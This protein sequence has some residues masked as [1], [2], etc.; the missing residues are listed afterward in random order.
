MSI[1]FTLRLDENSHQLVR[2][3][4]EYLK[5]S[6]F[7]KGTIRGYRA[8]VNVIFRLLGKLELGIRD[9]EEAQFTEEFFKVNSAKRKQHLSALKRFL[10]IKG[11]LPGKS[12][13]STNKE[14]LENTVT[15]YLQELTIRGYKEASIISIRCDT[16]KF[17][18]LC[19]QKGLLTLDSLSPKLIDDFLSELFITKAKVYCHNQKIKILYAVRGFFG[20][21]YTSGRTLYN[22]ANHVVVPKREKKLSRNFFSREEVVKLF[23]VVD[24][25]TLLGF[26]DR[27]IF[28]VLYVTGM[29]ISE[30]C[31]LRCDDA[32]K[33]TGTLYVKE[34][35]G[36]QDRYVPLGKTAG[37]YLDLYLADVR[38]RILAQAKRV[39]HSIRKSGYLFVTAKGERLTECVITRIIGRYLADAG[40]T[41]RRTAH[42]FRYSCATHLLENGA[43]I[44]HI[45]GLLGHR[46]LDTTG[47]YAKVSTRNM[48]DAIRY[49]PRE[50][51]Q[52]SSFTGQRREEQ[53]NYSHEL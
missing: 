48:L 4:Y 47:L 14:S 46:K 42:A 52:V 44:R 19:K 5:K 45:A 49:H 2:E 51:E 27:T 11:I 43:D 21:L 9:I 26:M 18:T 39:Y 32:N 25:D 16:K 31:N 15:A 38:P 22:L 13:V 10:W 30:L 17:L 12:N 53:R 7:V 40:I 33:S 50:G 36:G 28:E 8:S 34:G 20:W 35:K 29:R 6:G 3:F 37:K 1:D 23:K 41:R 24:T